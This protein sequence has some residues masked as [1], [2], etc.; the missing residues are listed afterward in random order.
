VELN[1]KTYGQGQPL[2]IMHGMFGMLD[3]WQ[4]IAKKLAEDYMVFLLDLRNH[5]RSPHSDEFGYD[6]M[7]EDLLRFMEENWLHRA[8]IVGHSMGGKVA[9]KFAMEN[10]DMVDKLVIVDIA[11]KTY[12]GNHESIIDA[13]I[14][15]DLSSINMRS[16]A[17][18]YLRHRIEE[19]S[20]IQFLL[21]N[22]SREKDA[23]YRWKMNLPVIVKHYREILAHDESH[24]QFEGPTLF[25]RGE[26]SNYIIPE[27]FPNFLQNFPNAKLATV[28]AAGHWVHAE[29]PEG[30]L[31]VLSDFL[32]S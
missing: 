7:S 22:L 19:E 21:K 15:L 3:N 13:L 18:A 8:H 29:N 31:Q 14:G 26:K 17:E 2:I 25:I 16:D 28:A 20:T 23:G 10:E 24:A 27:E 1:F 30:F 12:E 5:G 9:M 11:P 6:I 32:K 4:L